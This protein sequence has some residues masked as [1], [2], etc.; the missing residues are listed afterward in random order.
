MV[1]YERYVKNVKNRLLPRTG[2]FYGV[3]DIKNIEEVKE[4]SLLVEPASP[5]NPFGA[6]VT[7][8]IEEEATEEEE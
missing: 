2:D 3:S 5:L 8:P 1:V 7:L 4:G 6:E